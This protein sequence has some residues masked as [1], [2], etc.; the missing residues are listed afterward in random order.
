MNQNRSKRFFLSLLAAMLVFHTGM[1]AEA[2]DAEKEER[3]QSGETTLT[4]VL[5]V[6]TETKGEMQ[7]EAGSLETRLDLRGLSEAQIRG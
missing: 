4:D 6:E 2:S 1:R 3:S 7:N 5:P